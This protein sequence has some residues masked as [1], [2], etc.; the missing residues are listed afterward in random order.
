M[1]IVLGDGG[2]RMDGD[3]V[4][5]QRSLVGDALDEGDGDVEAGRR[6]PMELTAEAGGAA[7]GVA[8]RK[9]GK[10]IGIHAGQDKLASLQQQ[11]LT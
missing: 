6:H 5:L 9:K 7:L 3:G 4:L 1:H 11:L 2:L 10:Q 8:M